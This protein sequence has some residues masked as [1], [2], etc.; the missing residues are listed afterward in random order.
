MGYRTIKYDV[1]HD[2]A[3]LTLNRPEMINGLNSA[4]RHEILDAVLDAG[5]SARVLMITGAG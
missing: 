4:M 2:V 1:V 5:R 3:T